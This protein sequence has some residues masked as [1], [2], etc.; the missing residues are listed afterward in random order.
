MNSLNHS[1]SA[2]A[3]FGQRLLWPGGLFAIVLIAAALRWH[4]LAAQPLWTD[5]L[6]SLVSAAGRGFEING[7]PRNVLISPAPPVTDMGGGSLAGVIRGQMCDT[8][9]PTYPLLLRYWVHFAYRLCP[10]VVSMEAVCRLPSLVLGLAGIAALMLI[11]RRLYGNVS[12]ILIGLLMAMAGEHIKLS[13]EARGYMLAQSLMLCGMACW[14]PRN[15]SGRTPAGWAITGALLQ[16]LAIGSHYLCALPVVAFHIALALTRHDLRHQVLRSWRYVGLVW[17]AFFATFGWMLF[18]QLPTVGVRNAWLVEKAIDHTT[19]TLGRLAMMPL[20]LLATPPESLEMTWKWGGLAIL[21]L[22]VWQLGR[23]NYI[24]PIM[25][26]LPLIVLM[27]MDFRSHASHLEQP[28]YGFVALPGLLL[29]LA[30]L[31]A[32]GWWMT[33]GRA[34]LATLL[35]AVVPFLPDAYTHLKEDWNLVTP[36]F[37]KDLNCPAVAVI[38]ADVDRSWEELMYMGIS[39]YGGTAWQRNVSG[40]ILITDPDRIS[41]DEVARITAAPQIVLFVQSPRTLPVAWFTN[42]HRV[43][44]T[45]IPSVGTLSI[46]GQ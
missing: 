14:F 24:G 3:S 20:Y 19:V 41:P 42:R 36:L 8:H 29:T 38:S 45:G 33:A 15:P 31:A 17:V 6:Y 46:W 39:T 27:A 28:R 25:M 21:L 18:T 5:E 1:L 40:V 9:P 44:Y 26:L 22:A 30:P 34:V 7:L 35:L 23:R 4:D 32:P 2:S 13:Q 43:G 10:S 37:A 11:V 12:A 16:T